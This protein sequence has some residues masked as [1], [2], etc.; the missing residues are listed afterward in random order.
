MVLVKTF[1]FGFLCFS[2]QDKMFTGKLQQK[3]M[4]WQSDQLQLQKTFLSEKAELES[5]LKG[6]KLEENK[7]KDKLMEAEAVIY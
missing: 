3:E 1:D 2:N 5:Q 6:S 7:L 4:D